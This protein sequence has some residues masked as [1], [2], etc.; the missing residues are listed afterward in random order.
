MRPDENPSI[1]LFAWL[2]FALL[3]LAVVLVIA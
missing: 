3:N 2:A 1:S